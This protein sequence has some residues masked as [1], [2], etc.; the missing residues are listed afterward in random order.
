MHCS[1]V[2]YL[3]NFTVLVIYTVESSQLEIYFRVTPPPNSSR[4]KMTSVSKLPTWPRTLGNPHGG[5]CLADVPV[6]SPRAPCV[7]DTT[8]VLQTL[9]LCL[10]AIS[11]KHPPSMGDGGNTRYL[12][13]FFSWYRYLVRARTRLRDSLACNPLLILFCDFRFSCSPFVLCNLLYHRSCI[14][15]ARFNSS[16]TS[17]GLLILKT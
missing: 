2:D 1:L 6:V 3:G 9:L 7:F 17:A 13:P 11:V 16:Y 5:S 10:W 14:S 4:V 8:Q 12:S 15:V